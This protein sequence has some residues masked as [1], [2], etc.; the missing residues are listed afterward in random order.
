MLDLELVLIPRK[1]ATVVSA[2][3]RSN[4]SQKP[5]TPTSSLRKYKALHQSITK[6]IR[7][8]P[9]SKEMAQI[10]RQI[11]EIGRLPVLQND[12]AQLHKIALDIHAISDSDQYVEVLANIQKLQ[13]T[14]AHRVPDI[15]IQETVRPAYSLEEGD[16]D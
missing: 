9:E 11:R 1:S 4:R 3:V 10:Q 16:D 6:A 8:N 13:N 15:E 2:I 5:K 7:D 12:Q 14:I